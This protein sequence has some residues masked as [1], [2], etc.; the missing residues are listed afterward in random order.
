MTVGIADPANLP[1]DIGLPK[2]AVRGREYVEKR[3]FEPGDRP[4]A[5]SDILKLDMKP[6]DDRRTADGKR[7]NESVKVEQQ[8]D[9]A[10]GTVTITPVVTRKE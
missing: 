1:E 10:S 4:N 6:L 3:A 7:E 8:G 5:A 2:N 9:N